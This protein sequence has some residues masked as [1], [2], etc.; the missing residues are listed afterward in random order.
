F[1]IYLPRVDSAAAADDQSEAPVAK[2]RGERVLVVDDEAALVA[3]TSEVL[4][5][6]GYEPVAFSDG[7]AALAGFDASPQD[8][9]A[10]IADEVMPGLTGTELARKLRERRA[11]LPIVLVSG[12]IGPMM[13]ERALAAGVD[14]ILK[15]PVQSRELAAAL[16][17]VL[18]AVTK[19]QRAGNMRAVS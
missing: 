11:D 7:A 14:E 4:K 12:Y 13:T 3:L 18:S 8:F 10:V 15:K 9:D 5:R 2:G 19:T 16:A 6:L 1:A 17:R